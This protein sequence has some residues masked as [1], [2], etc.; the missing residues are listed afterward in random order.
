MIGR[1]RPPGRRPPRNPLWLGVLVV[2][3]VVAV[4]YGGFHKRL[5][6]AP[7][8]TMQAVF[9]SA[10]QVRKGSPVRIAGV[11][12]GKVIGV[13]RGP[14]TTALV[15]MEIAPQGRP[16]HDDATLAIRPRLF[17]EG[18][19]YVQLSPGS[20]SAPTIDKGHTIPLQQTTTPVQF[21]TVL[22]TFDA[23]TRASL[24]EASK[25]LARGLSGG[26]ARGLREAFTQLG[27]TFRAAA[28]AARAAQGSSPD[29]VS[30]LIGGAARVSGALAASD[31]QLAGLLAAYARVSGAIAAQDHKL[32][33]TVRGADSLLTAA[34]PSLR[35]VD[36]V[37]PTVRAFARALRPSLEIAPPILRRASGLLGELD[38]LLQPS[39]LPAFLAATKPVAAALPPLAARLEV[40]FPRVTPVSSCVGNQALSTLNAQV[41]DGALST[42]R[43]V[44]QDLAHGFV[45]L[46]GDNQSF[47]ANGFWLRYPG[48]VGSQLLSTVSLPGIAPLLGGTSNPVL[49][50][51][52]GWL[53]TGGGPAF[54][55]DVECTTQSPPDLASVASTAARE[56]QRATATARPRLNARLRRALLGGGR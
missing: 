54:R 23:P 11:D 56:S 30:T 14:G 17:L 29:D 31:S 5:P 47:D 7:R 35:A 36:R 39:E 16:L 20:P 27:P 53:G 55:P 33:A 43:P 52:P 28:I 21:F 37:L 24:A 10:N 51:R 19:F 38:A 40:L 12:V 44:W 3:L 41:P 2:V 45:G 32:A 9:A 46:S 49:G 1:R 25:Q 8:W 34:P 18:G 48:S 42:G 22:S 15:R 26:G 6:F 13:D 4:T 50:S